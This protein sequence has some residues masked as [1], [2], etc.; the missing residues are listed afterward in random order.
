MSRSIGY[1][2]PILVFISSP[3]FVPLFALALV[4]EGSCDCCQCLN[5]DEESSYSGGSRAGNPSCPWRPATAQEI[6]VERDTNVARLQ[7][8]TVY[9]Y[10]HKPE[11]ETAGV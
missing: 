3:S 1:M 11:T 4:Q 6:E 10:F 9:N 2:T 5:L 8:T 7:K